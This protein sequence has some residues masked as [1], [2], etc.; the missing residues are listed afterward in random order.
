[1]CNARTY[2]P[3]LEK[4]VQRRETEASRSKERL[5]LLAACCH[6]PV[7][8]TVLVHLWPPPSVQASSFSFRWI[9]DDSSS[10]AQGDGTDG[11]LCN[12]LVI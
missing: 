4:N 9:G 2:V 1:M 7:L 6:T 10:H 12:D 3:A 11:C 5:C 8:S